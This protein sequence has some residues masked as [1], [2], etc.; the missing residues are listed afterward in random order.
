MPLPARV[1]P[2]RRAPV[3]L[4]E[5]IGSGA[6]APNGHVMPYFRIIGHVMP[7]CG[8]LQ[9]WAALRTGDFGVSPVAILWL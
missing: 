3:A 2:G 8:R 9:E 7:Y 1:S 5:A 6:R 4:G